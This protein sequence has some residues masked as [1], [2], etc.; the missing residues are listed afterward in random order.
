MKTRAVRLLVVLLML[1]L[2]AC[3]QTTKAVATHALAGGKV[4]TLL[5]GVFELRL[6]LNP[7]AAFSML[8]GVGAAAL[9]A[10]Q[11][12]LIVGAAIA[13]HRLRAAGARAHV[14]FA[15]LIAG[16]LANL[17]DRAL[18]GAVVDFLHLRR[19]PIFNVADVAIVVGALLLALAVRAPRQ[20]G[21]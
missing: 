11:L 5:P 7:G 20:A 21:A 15:L 17:A 2:F 16:A 10:L 18:R 3:D 19:W 6:A 1:G 14:A 8:S 4:V 9:S 12:A 13:W